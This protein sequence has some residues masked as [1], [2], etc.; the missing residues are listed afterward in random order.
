LPASREQL[1]DAVIDAFPM[2][3]LPSSMLPT[4]VDQLVGERFGNDRWN[5]EFA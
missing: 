4:R 5:Y 1:V 2:A 3:S